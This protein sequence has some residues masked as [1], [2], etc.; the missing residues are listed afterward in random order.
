L[1]GQ[2]E[3]LTFQVRASQQ[4][5]NRYLKLVGDSDRPMFTAKRPVPFY[6][7]LSAL[8]GAGKTPILA[9]AVAQIALTMPE[10][11]IVL[12]ISKAKAVV[13][14]T[15]ANMEQGGKYHSLNEA[16]SVEYLSD[17][18]ADAIADGQTPLLALATVGT[19]NQKVKGEGTLTVHKPSEDSLGEESLWTTLTSRKSVS[20]K[21]RPLLIVYDEAQNLSDQQTDLLL[22]LD[23]DAMFVASATMKT[24]GKLGLLIERLKQEG[25]TDKAEI[26]TKDDIRSCLV[27]AVSS[28]AVVKAGL[29]KQQI[30]LGGYTSI[31]ETM[32]D[33][34]LTGMDMAREKAIALQAGFEPKAIY[35]CKTN[36]NQDDGSTDLPSR[37]FDQR[38]AP[39]ILIWRYLVEKKGVD[40][41]D[42]AVYCDLKVDRTDNP[43]PEAFKLFSGGEQDFAVFSA[44]NYKHIIFNLALQEGWD[45]PACAFAY[46]DKSMGSGIQVEQIIGRV[47]RQPGAK[48]HPDPDLNTANFYIRVDNKQEFP[49]ILKA[50]QA[51]IAAEMPE[52][53]ID[54]YS[55]PSAFKKVSQQ[56]KSVRAVPEIHIDASEV[57]EPLQNALTGII[58]F[59]KN[60]EATFG[61]G[62][63]H[64]VVQSI[65]DG[66]KGAVEVLD[67]PH[68]NRVTARWLMRRE[69]RMLHPE[70]VKPI[71]FGGKF[72]ALIEITSTAATVLRSAAEDL[73]DIFL[74]NAELAFEEANPYVVG[75]VLANPAKAKSYKHALH[76]SYDLNTL[77]TEIAEAID[78]AGYDWVR[79][80]EN[81]GY[82]IPLLDK[83]D[84]RRFFPD[85]LVWKDELVFAIDPKGGHLLTD[86]AWRKLL[87]IRDEKGQRR[88]LVRLISEGKWNDEI[89]KVGPAGYTVWSVLKTTGKLRA[90]PVA[91]VAEAVAA[92]LKP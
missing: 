79:N 82:S 30:I 73:V 33:D 29:V 38:K 4:I 36:V 76:E 20:G 89:Q 34:M 16:F 37:P 83:G 12:W 3:L 68:S 72:D 9:D 52:V 28:K 31:P 44:G 75:S 69:M 19:F 81:G 65:G 54:G 47:L 41:A 92:A 59:R 26:D 32:I 27:T 24:P 43:L 25:W 87:D 21:R 62:E 39:P 60:L 35:V 23:P 78:D 77:E 22:A 71:E 74:A 13:D 55:D 2:I 53:Q 40:P 90:R 17:L 67:I 6:Q 48:H 10:K 61:P 11:P 15:F 14:Q 66:S 7:A 46:I 84:T 63:L 45:D 58:D 5:V 50:V 42:I 85:F 1:S 57:S 8:T 18:T 56:P 49:R 86:A 91:T 80:P 70:A 88:V 51:K 64:R